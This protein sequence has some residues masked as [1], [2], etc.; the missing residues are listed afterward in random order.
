MSNK[1]QELE[2]LRREVRELRELAENGQ[3]EPARQ[4][5]LAVRER[6]ERIGAGAG[7]LVWFQAKLCAQL[8]DPMAALD[9]LAEASAIDPLN[10]STQSSF[11][12]VCG[13]LRSDL[14]DEEKNEAERSTA[15]V[16]EK[17]AW[18]GETDEAC[19]LSMARCLK[20]TG[21]GMKAMELLEA[22]TLLAPAS[23]EAWRLRLSLARELGDA[24]AIAECEEVL[25]SE[26]AAGDP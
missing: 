17:L 8:G 4:R 24:A 15:A 10:P 1:G 22:V 11:N 21:E 12:A 9:L 7:Y 5:L 19:H 16:Y 3:L 18:A 25:G 23:V 2:K 26:P 20:A 13:Q 14:V 6:A